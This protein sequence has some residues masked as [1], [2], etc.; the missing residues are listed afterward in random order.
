MRAAFRPAVRLPSAA[1]P[2]PATGLVLRADPCDDLG[3]QHEDKTACWSFANA[4]LGPDGRDFVLIYSDGDHDA[5]VAG[6]F[7]LTAEG[8]RVALRRPP[9][10]CDPPSRRGR[11]TPRAL[12]VCRSLPPQVPGL[13]RRSDLG[14]RGPCWATG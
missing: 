5:H 14:R 6:R 11:S 12:T 10:G 8:G 13:P 4:W 2:S 3:I 1:V 9:A 7:V